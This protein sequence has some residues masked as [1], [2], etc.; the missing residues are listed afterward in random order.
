[1]K[2]FYKY[3]IASFAVNAGVV[4]A[5]TIARWLGGIGAEAALAVFLVVGCAVVA[6]RDIAKAIPG[7]VV[8]A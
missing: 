8:S 7:A 2:L 6:Y 1:M 3:L 5:Y 4:T